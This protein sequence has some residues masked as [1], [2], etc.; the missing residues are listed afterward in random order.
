MRY[1]S[2]LNK[3]LFIYLFIYYEYPFIT[4]NKNKKTV[5]VIL[6]L[7]RIDSHSF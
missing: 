1:V 6:D 7:Y 3:T 4:F 5:I 2:T